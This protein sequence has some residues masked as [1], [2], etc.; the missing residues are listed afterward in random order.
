MVNSILCKLKAQE[1]EA[2]V[3]GLQAQNSELEKGLQELEGSNFSHDRG[4][5]CIIRQL[6]IVQVCLPTRVL[7]F[8][9]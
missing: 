7:N 6:A 8:L 1:L 3:A 5:G 2:K 4:Q 9:N